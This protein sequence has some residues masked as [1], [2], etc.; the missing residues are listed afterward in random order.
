MAQGMS[1]AY[2]TCDSTHLI[3]E[4]FFSQRKL[5]IAEPTCES[6]ES[7][8]IFASPILQPRINDPLF[9]N[10]FKTLK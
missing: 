1:M 6:R 2:F 10:H 8:D 3:D 7:F 4:V 9:S 5:W